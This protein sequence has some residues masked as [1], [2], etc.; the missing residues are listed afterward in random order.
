MDRGDDALANRTYLT[1]NE[2]LRVLDISRVTL[3]RW[4]KDG[5]IRMEMPEGT[6][7]WRVPVSEVRK[8]LD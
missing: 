8:F 6:R 2:T 3:W 7:N 4:R 5:Y 1:I